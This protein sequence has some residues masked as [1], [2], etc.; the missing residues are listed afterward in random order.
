M[1]RVFNAFHFSIALCSYAHVWGQ[2]DNGPLIA[3]LTLIPL[4]LNAT[5]IGPWLNMKFI[6]AQSA[7]MSQPGHIG[8]VLEDMREARSVVKEVGHLLRLRLQMEHVISDGEIN[9][10]MIA[11]RRN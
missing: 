2:V 9:K 5:V 6:V 7:I 10:E 8:E 11:D 3:L 1:G 4:L